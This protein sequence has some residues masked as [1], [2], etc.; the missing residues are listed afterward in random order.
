MD[1]EIEFE[2]D[3]LSVE[4][5]E[6][7]MLTLITVLADNHLAYRGTLTNMCEFFGIQTRDSRS[8]AKI[9]AAIK[10][11]EEKGLIKTLL[12]GR[13][14]TLT[15]SRSAERKSKVIRIKRDWVNA[16]R[17]CK[18]K[19]VDWSA[20][21]KVWLYLIDNKADIIKSSEIAEVLGISKSVV[22]RARGILIELNAIK[23]DKINQKAPNG[24]IYCLGSRVEVNAWIDD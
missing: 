2:K 13:T 20:I 23:V 9:R 1:E 18:G 21:L 22:S 4:K 15:L 24:K 17:S 3:W 7:K 11:L 6:F 8:N 5:L 16:V 19:S 10:N 14:W 12:D